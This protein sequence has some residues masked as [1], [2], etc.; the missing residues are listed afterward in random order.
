MQKSTKKKCQKTAK[1]G[2]FKVKRP[3]MVL[4]LLF[5]KNLHFFY[6]NLW[7]FHDLTCLGRVKIG[8][9]K[10]EICLTLIIPIGHKSSKR[11]YSVLKWWI[12]SCFFRIYTFFTIT[13]EI[14]M[15]IRVWEGSKTGVWN[16]QMELKSVP[17]EVTNASIWGEA[18]P[19]WCQNSFIFRFYHLHTILFENL[20]TLSARE[21]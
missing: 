11:D 7:N 1:E 16:A 9:S 10:R 15:P 6:Y 19:K 12:D 14:F 18:S 2:D 13:S 4:W 21:G 20:V 5:F 3:K 8:L 17:E